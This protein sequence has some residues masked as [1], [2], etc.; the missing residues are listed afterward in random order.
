[1]QITKNA[2]THSTQHKRKQHIQKLFATQFLV[3]VRYCFKHVDDLNDIGNEQVGQYFRTENIKTKFYDELAKVRQRRDDGLNV[4]IPPIN[5]ENDDNE[6]ENK[7]QPK[8][9]KPMQRITAL[10]VKYGEDCWRHIFSD[11][12]LYSTALAKATTISNLINIHKKHCPKKKKAKF[13]PLLKTDYRSNN[14]DGYSRSDAINGAIAEFINNKFVFGIKSK[15]NCLVIEA[16]VGSAKTTMVGLLG[17][18]FKVYYIGNDHTW[19]VGCAVL[20]TFLYLDVRCVV[21]MT[22]MLFPTFLNV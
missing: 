19:Y 12:T 9:P 2:F 6:H 15:C 3:W 22:F 5:E 14:N 13:L 18:K 10:I 8:P 1:M 17:Q 4:V 7:Q 11:P 21:S 20:L 16:P